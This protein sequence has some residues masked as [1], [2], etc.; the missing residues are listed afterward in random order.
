MCYPYTY[1]ECMNMLDQITIQPMSSNILRRATLTKTIAGNQIEMLI[2]TNFMSSQDAIA[3]RKCV[4][5]TG[6]VHPGESNSSY[7]M[8][9]VIQFLMSDA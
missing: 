1:T 5:L 2:I 9:G 3:K 4:I 6:R 7:V 8:E